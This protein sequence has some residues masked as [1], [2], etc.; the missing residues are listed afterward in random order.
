MAAI[1]LLRHV[2]IRR[3]LTLITVL[4]S[5]LALLIAC[6][7]LMTYERVVYRSNMV[8][9]LSTTAAMIA[10]N[11]SAALTFSDPASAQQ[12]LRSLGANPH[13]VGAAIYDLNGAVFA[14]YQRAGL[15]RPF[16]PPAVPQADVETFSNDRLKLF[17]GIVLAGERV[18]TVYIE[19][20]LTE[21]R[22]RV[23]RYLMIMGLVMALASLAALALATALQTSISAPVSHLAAVMRGVTAE[24]NYALRALKGGDDELGALVDGFNA[25]LSQIQAQDDA[26]HEAH[27]ELEKRVAARTAELERIHRQLLDASRQAGMAEI[28]T[29]VLHNVGNVLNSVNV[30][31]ILVSEL[32]QRSKAA[33]LGRVVALMRANEPDLGAFVSSDP[34]GRHLIGHLENLA[35]HL[36][37]EQGQIV[38]EI[39]SLRTNIAHIK[40]IVTMQQSYAKVAGVNEIVGA[41]ELVEDSLRMNAGALARHG[42]AVRRDYHG[43]PLLNCDKHKVLQILVNLVRNAKYACEESH[44]PDKCVTLHV[45]SRADRVRIAVLDNGTGIAPENMTRIFNHGF[46]TRATGHGFGL[47]SGALAARELGGSLVAASEG[48]GRGA[49]FTLELPLY[50]VNAA[51]AHSR[52]GPGVNEVAHG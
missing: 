5:G 29:N 7:A 23:Q 13:L 47:H 36:H 34:R 11:S 17:H 10:D 32:A 12:T 28:A 24:K 43:A 35:Q 41:V 44:S 30:S 26:L 27:S 8:S 25:M 48:L 51:V 37:V 9:E 45:S 20:D 4:A 1:H 6:L 52:L 16:V 31:A 18:G 42:V 46:T 40:D 38:R 19:S 33:G 49:T 22:A 50:S 39:E 21:M 3:K 14:Q 2:P 15:P